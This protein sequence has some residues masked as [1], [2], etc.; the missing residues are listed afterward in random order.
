MTVTSVPSLR[1]DDELEPD[2]ATADHREAATR[3]E[4]RANPRGVVERPEHDRIGAVGPGQRQQPRPGASGEKQPLVRQLRPVFER[5][6]P[7]LPVDRCGRRARPE[8]DAG[9]GETVSP[10]DT[11]RLRDFGNDGILGQRR[12]LVGRVRLGADQR[13]RP[14]VTPLPE[15]Q[16][17]T[18]AASPAP[19]ITIPVMGQASLAARLAA[20]PSRSASWIVAICPPGRAI[21][22]V[23]ETGPLRRSQPG[24]LA[25]RR[26]QADAQA[27]KRTWA[28]IFDP[29]NRHGWLLPRF[30]SEGVGG[31]GEPRSL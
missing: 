13:D 28:T 24:H 12:P 1:A 21:P 30:A 20:S 3:A 14:G 22:A 4:S 23:A 31:D 5:Y 7:T 11:L 29:M 9:G 25:V 26:N 18:R 27:D 19:T 2:E 16:C 15:R 17:S 6:D 10:G 8:V